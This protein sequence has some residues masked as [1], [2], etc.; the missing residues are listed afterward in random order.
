MT[1][2]FKEYATALFELSCEENSLDLCFAEL[3]TIYN[4]LKDNPQYLKLL[5]SNMIT[6]SEKYDL[7][8]KAFIGINGTLMNF[9]KL[10]ISKRIIIAL[11]KCA[12]C[13]FNLYYEEQD[14]ILAEVVS[15]VELTEDEKQE[16][17]DKLIRITNKKDVLLSSKI[18]SSI[19]GGAILRFSGQEMDYSLKSRLNEMKLRLTEK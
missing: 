15:A 14:I 10:L 12:E 2:N 4:V 5:N 17:R 18:D 7:A 3:S 9:I 6:M 19:I 13:F 1:V 16:I 8:E 11:P